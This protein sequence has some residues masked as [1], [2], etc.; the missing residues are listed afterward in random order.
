MAVCRYCKK[1]GCPAQGLGPW[2][3]EVEHWRGGSAFIPGMPIDL[4]F[5]SEGFHYVLDPDQAK[6]HARY[7]RDLD[8]PNRYT[9]NPDGRSHGVQSWILARKTS[10]SGEE[11][12]V[13]SEDPSTTR[14][15]PKGPYVFS[16]LK[17]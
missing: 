15:T 14:W 2:G 13:L 5:G 11:S 6:V 10:L 4:Y 7:E 8:I 12:L 16:L 17:A 1:D 9:L 3:E